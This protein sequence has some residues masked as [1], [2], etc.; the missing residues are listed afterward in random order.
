MCL[1]DNSS[2]M[3]R[4]H[5]HD[6]VVVRYTHPH[7]VPPLE[8]EGTPRRAFVAFRKTC[9]AADAQLHRHPPYAAGPLPFKGRDRVGMGST[10]T[11]FTDPESKPAQLTRASDTPPSAGTQT[12]RPTCSRDCT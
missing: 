1:L 5:F 8:G 9:A 11:R 6:V 4:H 7:P 2:G 3:F 12:A 10:I